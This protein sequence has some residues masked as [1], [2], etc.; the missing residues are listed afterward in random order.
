MRDWLS[1]L[2][3]SYEEVYPNKYKKDD[4]C[5]NILI[6][7]LPG[8][9]QH[10]FDLRDEYHRTYFTKQKTWIDGEGT[11]Q[12]EMDWKGRRVGHGRMVWGNDGK[13]FAGD[14]VKDKMEGAG[15]IW[16]ESTG[17]CYSGEWRSGMMQGRGTLVYGTRSD[18]PGSVYKGEFRNGK[19]SGHGTVAVQGSNK[20][21]VG[22]F[23]KNIV[24]KGNFLIS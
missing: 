7:S 24:K 1:D 15:V 14:W 20:K 12:G 16:W 3:P 19:I 23:K 9:I 2:P 21:L 22:F 6:T 10:L 17:T 18:T 5:F 11:Y 4:I 8:D 13:V